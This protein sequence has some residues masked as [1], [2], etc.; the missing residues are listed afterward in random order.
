M[1]NHNQT[2]KIPDDP[3]LIKS[4]KE[5]EK[6]P[7]TSK[8]EM[9]WTIT[10]DFQV[11]SEFLINDIKDIQNR[12][13][14]ASDEYLYDV[15]RHIFNIIDWMTLIVVDAGFPTFITIFEDLFEKE[16]GERN[17]LQNIYNDCFERWISKKS[18]QQKIGENFYNI[19]GGKIYYRDRF[20]QW[21]VVDREIAF[22]LL[23]KKKP[24]ED[25]NIID[26]LN[27]EYKETWYDII[28]KQWKDKN[29]QGVLPD[30][31]L[32]FEKDETSPE[33]YFEFTMNQI[34]KLLE[35]PVSIEELERWNGGKIK[36]LE[37]IVKIGALVLDIVKKTR[38]DNSHTVYLLRDCL[39]FYEA[40]KTIDILT[41]KETS[42]DQLLIGRKLLSHKLKDWG[43]Y[44]LTL[45]SLYNA[46]IRYPT[47]FEKFYG[48]YTRL[49]DMFVSLNPGFAE[50]IADLA[51]YIKK[52]IKTDKKKVIVFD[53][54]FQGSIALLTKYIIDNHINPSNLDKKI[55]IDIEVGVGAL[56]SKELFG[57]RHLGDYFPFLNR[58]QL[59]KRRKPFHKLARNMIQNRSNI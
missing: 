4:F 48:D 22:E 34:K 43:Y 33:E 18:G 41:S 39:M 19:L 11:F 21:F 31:F 59:M 24:V 5:F 32:K 37:H 15:C 20:N 3:W 7:T 58:L 12:L 25:K 23:P 9:D 26:Q 2:N 50:V 13:E 46:H 51:E 56:W 52:H 40:H 36:D 47:D 14:D 57:D 28:L 27:K 30:D 53:I 29:Y 55:E 16:F 8:A 17:I 6:M 42:A 45:E 10:L 49:L 35:N 1:S 44:I 38:K 54:G